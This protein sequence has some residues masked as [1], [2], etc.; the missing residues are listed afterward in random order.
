MALLGLLLLQFALGIGAYFARFTEMKDVGA[1]LTLLLLPTLH[2]IAGA[3]MLAI[4]VVV[5]LRARRHSGG[6]T[7]TVPLE[8]GGV[9]AASGKGRALA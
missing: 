7:A 8:L 9:H 3:A 2:R 5:A 6:V 4:S 1:P